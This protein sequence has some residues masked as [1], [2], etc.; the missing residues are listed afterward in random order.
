MSFG[1]LFGYAEADERACC[2]R[3]RHTASVFIARNEYHEKTK[4]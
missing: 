1:I 2:I 3:I 4:G